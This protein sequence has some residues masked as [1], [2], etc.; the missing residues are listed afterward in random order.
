VY[1]TK[2]SLAPIYIYEL[3]NDTSLSTLNASLYASSKALT[4]V[5]SV[6]SASSSKSNSANKSG[7][8]RDVTSLCWMASLEKFTYKSSAS[9]PSHSKVTY[10]KMHDGLWDEIFDS[11]ADDPKV[12]GNERS[13]Q[14][15]LHLLPRRQVGVFHG[16]LNDQQS[17]NTDPRLTASRCFPRLFMSN[18]VVP[19]SSPDRLAV[20]LP[21]SGKTSL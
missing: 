21:K 2:S 19:P 8:Y 5:L 16:G 7:L 10:Q 6:T 12:A 9:S 1:I 13:D 4:L 17:T 11:L 14:V 15:G 20:R 18:A 3:F